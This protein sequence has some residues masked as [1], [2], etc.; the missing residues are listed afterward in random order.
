MMDFVLNELVY[1]TVQQREREAGAGRRPAS[2]R[3]GRHM[4]WAALKRRAAL[5]ARLLLSELTPGRRGCKLGT[6]SRS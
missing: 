1:A 4:L 2:G 6:A 3:P 5:G